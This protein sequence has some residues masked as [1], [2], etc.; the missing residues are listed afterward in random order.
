MGTAQ[1]RIIPPDPKQHGEALADLCA[2][3]FSEFGYYELLHDYRR[4]YLHNSHYDWANSRIGLLGDRIITHIGV[5]DYQMRIGA[6]RVRCGGLGAVATDPAFRKRGFMSQTFSACLQAMRQS[7]Y[8]FSILFGISGFYHR[9]GYV[10]AWAGTDFYVRAS[11]LPKEPPSGRLRRFKLRPR[12]DLSDLYNHCYS[13]ST[14]TAVRPTYRKGYPHWMRQDRGY[15]WLTGSGALSGYVLARRDPG[16]VDCIE[17]CGDARQA[18]RVLGALARR[19]GSGTVHFDSL[20]YFSELAK[21]LR[22]GNCRTET[23]HQQSGGAMVQLLNLPDALR[24]MGPELSRRPRRSPL[25]DWEGNLL[26]ADDREE[27]ALHIEGGRVS[28]SEPRR[29]SHSIRGDRYIAQLL[30]GSS[31]PEE[32]VE[33]GGIPL[34]GEAKR[35]AHVLFPDQRPMLSALDRY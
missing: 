6:A 7:G 17:Y 22:R 28:T 30:L 14:G 35:L 31:T 16:H 15:A 5:L 26:I 3:V 29:T 24:K 25:A 4:I 18:L 11:D 1:L 33:A 21:L 19:W 9:F 8:D 2:K 12:P 34:R 20:P 32:T 23:R 10:P 13:A 27:T